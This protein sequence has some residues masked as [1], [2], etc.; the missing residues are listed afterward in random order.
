M[1]GV[2]CSPRAIRQESFPQEETALLSILLIRLPHRNFISVQTLKDGPAW[3]IGEGLSGFI[4]VRWTLNKH[5]INEWTVANVPL[6]S[7]GH[8]WP[9]DGHPRVCP[10]TGIPP[11]S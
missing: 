5:Y 2:N 8:E 7:D 6:M 9:A 10:I 4:V 11:R 1:R 3:S